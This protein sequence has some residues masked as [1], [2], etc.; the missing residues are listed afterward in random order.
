V[1]ARRWSGMSATR[2]PSATSRLLKRNRS[3]LGEAGVIENG[4][5]NRPANVERNSGMR[6]HAAVKCDTMS[7]GAGTMSDVRPGRQGLLLIV[8]LALSSI[9]LFSFPP[10]GAA[11][12]IASVGHNNTGHRGVLRGCVDRRTGRL[13]LIGRTGNSTF[14]G[15]QARRNTRALECPRASRLCRVYR[16]PGTGSRSRRDRLD[17]QHRLHRNGRSTWTTR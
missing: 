11:A 10:K 4:R 1:P 5:G 7:E 16:V 6:Y 2:R 12:P 15:M 3:G 14:F 17:W 9:A 8:A 13:K